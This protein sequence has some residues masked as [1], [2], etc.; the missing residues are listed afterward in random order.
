M[1]GWLIVAGVA[2][3]Q[4]GCLLV[5]AGAAGGA[6]LGYAYCKGN[7]CQAY[8]ASFP[9]AWTATH[10]ALAELGF[11]VCKEERE[12][13]GGWI[14][15]TATNGDRI[16]I[17]LDVIDNPVPAGAPLTRI[18][19]RVATFGDSPLSERILNQVD[20]HLAPANVSG[21]VPGAGPASNGLPP[22]A[23]QPPAAPPQSGEPPLVT[24]PPP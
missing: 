11:S 2:L 9:D 7:V 4:S 21:T 19:V 22:V 5:A 24:N 20:I 17:N 23:L 1:L 16:V 13:A 18:C 12:A 15:T 14:Q 6:A 8:N 10:T 3:A